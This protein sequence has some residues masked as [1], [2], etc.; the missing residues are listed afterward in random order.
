MKKRIALFLALACVFAL[1]GC[2]N[3][4]DGK[5][6][7]TP[8][9]K[10][11]FKA[12]VLEVSDDYLLVEP[13]EG[14]PERKSADRIRISTGG[15]EEEQSLR[16]LAEAGVDDTVEIAYDG[17]IAESYPAQINSADEIKLVTKAES[18]SDKIPMVMVKGE[19]YYD[20]GRESTFVSRCGTVDGEIATTVDASQIPEEDDQSNFGVGYGYQYITETTIEVSID[21]NWAVFEQRPGDGSTA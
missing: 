14:T 6:T 2:G 10:T 1:A 4:E 11:Y 8:A 3:T 15:I 16:Y 7:E 21:G 12:I 19:L 18:L 5:T 9:A 17:T 20:T 13:L